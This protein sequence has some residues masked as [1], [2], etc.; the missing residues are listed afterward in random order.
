M[1][2]LL[3]PRTDPGALVQLIATLA[4]GLPLLLWLRRRRATELSWFVGGLLVF[5]LGVYAFRT[6]H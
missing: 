6:V 1:L 5:L 4:V 3:L 2:E